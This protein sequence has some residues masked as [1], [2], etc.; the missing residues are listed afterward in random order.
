M[1]KGILLVVIL[2][3]LGAV[4]LG[5][6]WFLHHRPNQ[7]APRYI[8]FGG[9]T[10]LTHDEQAELLQI[11]QE[12]ASHDELLEKITAETKIASRWNISEEEAV[13]ELKK[14][15]ILNLNPTKG[16]QIGFKGKR[17]EADEL[18]LLSNMAYQLIAGFYVQQKPEHKAIFGVR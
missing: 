3:L 9:V 7:P 14:R 6:Y 17:K 12:V 2:A 5:G 4:G 8:Q 10:Q 13:S 18:N 15:L 16:L 1:N 11:C